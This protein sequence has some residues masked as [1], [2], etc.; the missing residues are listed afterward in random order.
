MKTKISDLKLKP[1]LC[2]ELHQLGF[3][4]V[5]DMQHLSNADILRIPGMGGVSY[6]RLA[7][8]LGRE[9]YGRH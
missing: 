3:E 4:I 7:A 2:D 8:A 1:S 5:D 9:P 6:R